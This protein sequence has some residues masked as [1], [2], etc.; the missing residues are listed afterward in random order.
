MSQGRIHDIKPSHRVKK[1][2]PVRARTSNLPPRRPVRRPSKG[3]SSGSG[4]G[5]WYVAIILIVALFFGLSIFFTGATVKVTPQTMDL[6]L[7]ERFVAHKK[8]VSTELT[9]DFMVVE[10]SVERVATSG[11]KEEVSEV[12]R[13]TVRIYNDSG[14]SE[15]PLLIDTRLVDEETGRIYKTVERVTVPGQQNIDGSTE[16]GFVDVDV[17]ADKPG[18]D[19]NEDVEL[20]L[21]LIGFKEADSPKYETIY[22]KTTSSLEGGFVGERYVL[23]DEQEEVIKSELQAELQTKLLEQSVAQAP[24]ASILPEKLSKLINTNLTQDVKDSGEITFVLEGSM[25]NVLFNKLELEG[26]II[27]TSVAGAEQGEIYIA[28]IED[29][30][31][32]YLDEQAQTVDLESLETLGFQI[33]DTLSIVWNVNEE[34]LV[35]DLVGQ[36]KKDFE[37][38]ITSY[39]SI[40]SAELVVKP[41]WR[42]RFPEADEDIEV[43]NTQERQ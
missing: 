18:E 36:K 16:P 31:I 40:E 22:A 38:I 8:A 29:L 34:S 32:T 42:G 23:G 25:F 11:T 7:N 30:N 9:F 35:F 39:D 26:F 10:G 20:E 4:K 43:F 28:N 33:D 6:T 1:E 5:V 17:Y 12:A 37:K 14:S 2:S 3:S 19:Y 24:E 21:R 15:Q 41:F 27:D 13:G